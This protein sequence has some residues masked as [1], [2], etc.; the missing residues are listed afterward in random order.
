MSLARVRAAGRRGG[1]TEGD[2]A[3]PRLDGPNFSRGTE[4]E[5]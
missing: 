5:W 2:G 4:V 1:R 3:P